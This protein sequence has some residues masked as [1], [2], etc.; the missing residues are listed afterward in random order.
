MSTSLKEKWNKKR[1]YSP[2]AH[3]YDSLIVLDKP[4]VAAQGDPAYPQLLKSHSR[5]Y[6]KVLT[7]KPTRRK[8]KITKLKVGRT[9]ILLCKIKPIS[10]KILLA[11][12]QYVTT[13]SGRLSTD[14]HIKKSLAAGARWRRKLWQKI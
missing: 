12:W 1:N 10:S 4:F 13:V 7:S 9:R 6:A 5:K 2:L 14:K 8:I 11:S 3:K